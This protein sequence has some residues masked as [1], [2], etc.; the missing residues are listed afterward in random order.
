MKGHGTSWKIKFSKTRRLKTFSSFCIYSLLNPSETEG[1][2]N[3]WIGYRG[4]DLDIYRTFFF[5][6]FLFRE[7]IMDV[8]KWAPKLIPSSSSYK[9]PSR[10]IFLPLLYENE[11]S[12]KRGKKEKKKKEKKGEKIRILD[13][14]SHVL[15]VFVGN[16]RRKEISGWNLYLFSWYPL[17]LF[18]FI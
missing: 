17:Y 6:P 8:A 2:E 4:D 14:I 12:C 7:L 13:F 1:K 10:F 16:E 15:L 9:I 3:I 18:Y 11:E 5:L